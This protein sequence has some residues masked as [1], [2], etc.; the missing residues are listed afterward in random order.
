M[1]LDISSSEVTTLSAAAFEFTNS[2]FDGAAK[3]NWDT[4]L[5]KVNP[6][7]LMEV[8]SYEGAS[9]C[10]IMQK[11]AS[12]RPIELHCVDTWD[13]QTQ[14]IEARF[15]KNVRLAQA[16]AKHPV[17]LKKHK[18]FSDKILCQLLTEGQAGSFDWIYIDGSHVASDV[19]FDTVLAFRL[20]KVGGVMAFDDYLWQ[21]KDTSYIDP[22]LCPKSAI[23]A[24]TTIYCQKIKILRL[25]L[26]QLYVKKTAE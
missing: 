17:T 12:E 5:L 10:Y 20:L 23:D 8:G 13:N 6:S 11:L 19:L 15:D 14:P 22:V 9:A 24:F 3:K 18:G 16:S 21:T 2:W 25:P 26:Y 4:L 1:Q 7:K